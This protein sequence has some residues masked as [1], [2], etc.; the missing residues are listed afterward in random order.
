MSI[1]ITFSV[2]HVKLIHLEYCTNR[3]EAKL[4]ESRFLVMR[5]LRIKSRKNWVSNFF[6]GVFSNQQFFGVIWEASK[7]LGFHI[8]SQ[9]T[10]M[11]RHK[12]IPVF[13][14]CVWVES[15]RQL[16][17]CLVSDLCLEVTLFRYRPHCICCVNQV[18]I[19]L[20]RCIYT[21]K[22]EMSVS[23]HSY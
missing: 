1:Y 15:K 7:W 12:N 9:F 5:N 21:T 3:V 17:S 13:S 14:I 23:N 6:T 11:F 22:V 10:V 4:I 20:I 18:S 2:Y 8:V 19:L 16:Y